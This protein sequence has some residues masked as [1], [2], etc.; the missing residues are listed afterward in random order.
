MLRI[1]ESA[2]HFRVAVYMSLLA[3]RLASLAPP[4]MYVYNSHDA[5]PPTA[6]FWNYSSE[7]VVTMVYRHN[8]YL[9][10]YRWHTIVSLIT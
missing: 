9:I 8:Y 5:Y 3:N 2:L 7:C 6:C 1:V 4:T 10:C